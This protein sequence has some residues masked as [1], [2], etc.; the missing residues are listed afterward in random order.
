ML[1]TLNTEVLFEFGQISF[2]TF[3]TLNTFVTVLSLNDLKNVKRKN[4]K[5]NPAGWQNKK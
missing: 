3:S 5:I 1:I 2:G 4:V